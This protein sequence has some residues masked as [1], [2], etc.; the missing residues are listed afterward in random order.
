MNGAV[1]HLGRIVNGSV[2]EGDTVTA[3]Y[4]YDRRQAIRRNHTSAHLV[5]AALRHVLGD[6][7]HQAGSYVDDQRMR[8]DFSHFSAMTPEEIAKVEKEVNEVILKGMDVVTKEMPIEEAKKIGAM[9]LFGEKYGEIVRV[10]DVPGFS[11]EFCGGT[12][13]DNTAKIGLFKIL[14]ES[15]VAAGVRRIEAVTGYGVLE[16]LAH[17][18]AEIHAIAS[19]LKLSNVEEIPAKVEALSADLR[20]KDKEIEALNQKIADSKVDG[21]F[22]KAQDID[23]ISCIVA[24]FG[25]TNKEALRTLGDKIRDRAPNAVAMLSAVEGEKGTL[26]VVCG[27]NA[28]SKGVHAGNLVKQIAALAGGKGGGRPDS[29]MAG[30]GDLFKLDEALAQAPDMIRTMIQK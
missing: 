17:R 1:V 28:V 10:V 25:G 19:S 21:L 22:E 16:Q 23:G 20:A 18:E 2:A 9:A 29:A 26:L 7:I 6:H 11:V 8:F 13:I 4:D 15:S 30:I 5:Q 3:V 27:K 24:G 14:S 12:H